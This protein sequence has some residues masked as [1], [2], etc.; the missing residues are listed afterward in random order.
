[1]DVSCVHGSVYR[2]V[3]WQLAMETAQL[4]ARTMHCSSVPTNTMMR[5]QTGQDFSPRHPLSARL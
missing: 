5:V 1:M 3:L 2:V 4:M